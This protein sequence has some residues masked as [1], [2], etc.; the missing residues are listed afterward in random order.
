MAAHDNPGD[1]NSIHHFLAQHRAR[2]RPALDDLGPWLTEALP[3]DDP[4]ARPRPAS[5]KAPSRYSVASS[6]T[7]HTRVTS[8][9]SADAAPAGSGAGT[10]AGSGPATHTVWVPSEDPDRRELADHELRLLHEQAAVPAPSALASHRMPCE[11]ARYTGCAA[12]FDAFSQT[13][14]W[15]RHVLEEHLDWAAPAACLCWF[16]DDFKFVVGP[17]GDGGENFRARMVHIAGHYQE[18]TA[19][20]VRP[21]F[22]FLDHVWERRLVGWEVFEREKRVHEAVQVEGLRPRGY[23]SRKVAREEERRGV[24]IVGTGREERE[25]R[26]EGRRARDK[27]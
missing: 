3:A 19:G 2:H 16:C 25:R 9:F 14:A 12:T 8:V 18:G 4:F 23:K 7:E 21:D 15:M 10:G 6:S 20:A 26:R 22:F 11:F 13:E 24:V 5:S 17:A 1:V 27:G